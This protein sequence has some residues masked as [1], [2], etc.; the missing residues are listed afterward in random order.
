MNPSEGGE[1]GPPPT[2]VINT[3]VEHFG[4]REWFEKIPE[5]TIVALQASDFEHDGAVSLF[6]TEAKLAEAFPLKEKIFS[7]RMKF[8]YGSWNFHRLMLIGVR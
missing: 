2:I 7:G 6:D 3:S 8:D 4:G 5:G 1:F